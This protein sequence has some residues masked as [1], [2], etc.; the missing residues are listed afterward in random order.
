MSAVVFAGN[1]MPVQQEHDDCM[2]A[3]GRIDKGAVGAIHLPG[4]SGASGL[5]AGTAS[6]SGHFW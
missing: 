1:R 6:A 5:P 4:W 2:F 3:N